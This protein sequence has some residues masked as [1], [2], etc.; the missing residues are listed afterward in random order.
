MGGRPLRI[1]AA[2]T[3]DVTA[4]GVMVT[5]TFVLWTGWVGEHPCKLGAV[6]TEDVT[7]VGVMVTLTLVVWTGG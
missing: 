3:E 2:I 6:I 1:G 5:L 7:A 4:V